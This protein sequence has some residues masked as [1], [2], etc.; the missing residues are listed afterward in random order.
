MSLRP[1][2]QSDP[3]IAPKNILDTLLGFLCSITLSVHN[4]G[5]HKH[6]RTK[7]RLAMTHDFATKSSVW[8]TSHLLVC[9]YVSVHMSAI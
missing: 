7:N 9:V 2:A 6:P 3:N 5:K 4:L 1:A 8:F